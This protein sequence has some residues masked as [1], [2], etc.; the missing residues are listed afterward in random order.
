M[1]DE[2]CFEL[3]FVADGVVV[4]R[5]IQVLRQY[6]SDAA[7]RHI[8]AAF[9]VVG[10]N[11]DGLQT[12]LMLVVFVIHLVENYSQSNPSE[13]SDIFDGHIQLKNSARR[14]QSQ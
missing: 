1:S 13:W 10:G 8:T 4:S 9:F 2:T 6:E 14:V 3:S 11:G 7:N 12:S 5:N